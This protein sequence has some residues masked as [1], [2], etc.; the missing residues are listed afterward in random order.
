M[1][2]GE[3]RLVRRSGPRFQRFAPKADVVVSAARIEQV[4][5]SGYSLALSFTFGLGTFGSGLLRGGASGLWSCV[6]ATNWR[7]AYRTER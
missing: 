6:S 4:G 1:K 7:G 5:I 2:N 3:V